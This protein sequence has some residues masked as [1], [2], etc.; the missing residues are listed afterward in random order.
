[1][2][3]VLLKSLSMSSS[4]NNPTKWLILIHCAP[5][6]HNARLAW[7]C[8]HQAAQRGE[9]VVVF[10]DGDAVWHA[11]AVAALDPGL[12]DLH[13]RYQSLAKN[14]RLMRLLVCRAGHARRSTETLSA[15]WQASGLTE[16]ATLV[17]QSQHVMTFSA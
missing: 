5:S 4:N 8:V 1:M 12:T 6:T 15:N 17:E 9:Q 10:F 3:R 11:Q 13:E 14:N 16:L 2:L 7:D